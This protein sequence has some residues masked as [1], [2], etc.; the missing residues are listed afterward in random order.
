MSRM[1]AHVEEVVR[2]FPI[3]GADFI[4]GIQVLGWECVA[5]KGD[6]KQGDKCVYIEIDSIVP[7]LPMFAFLE[8][9]RYRVKTIKLKKQISQ[10]L[11]MPIDEALLNLLGKKSSV[12]DLTIGEDVTESMGIIQHLS[13]SDLEA[14]EED[15]D[16]IKAPRTG[17]GR[18]ANWFYAHF[19]I[20]RWFYNRI[21]P[22]PP[23]GFP[24]WIPKTDEDRI[25]NAPIR[26]MD[27]K[28]PMYSSEKLD[29]QSVTYAF[30]F[31][32]SAF[33]EKPN[34]VICSR[35]RRMGPTSK[36]SWPRV[37]QIEDVETKLRKAFENN[38]DAFREKPNFV[39]CSR[40]RR[41]GPTS[42]GSWPRVAQIEDVEAKLRK[43][44]ENN[45]DAGYGAVVIQGE[46]IGPGIQKNRYRREDYEMYVFNVMFRQTD[47]TLIYLSLDNMKH[48]CEKYGFRM[49]PIIDPDFKMKDTL[50]EM[51]KYADG[52][53]SIMVPKLAVNREGVVIRS[54]NQSLSFKIISN[55]FL[56][57][58]ESEPEEEE[59]L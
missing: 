10:G 13:K 9:R 39:I 25:Q 30:W 17:M 7:A 5:K 22:K 51:I 44:F 1:L 2:V 55:K 34:F 11:A 40:N 28:D 12:D 6:L 49:V 24:S 53:T 21:F 8:E 4:E 59:G 54:H 47:G 46:I 57:Q 20:F 48:F 52:K 31:I 14:R 23:K 36:G 43:A 32:R 58:A 26:Y 35:N 18:I 15:E 37:A 3:P 50:D 45:E 56:L 27:C 33:R 29:G 41:M 42:K 19:R 38:E 16:E